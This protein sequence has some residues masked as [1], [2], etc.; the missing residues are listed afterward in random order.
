MTLPGKKAAVEFCWNAYSLCD[1][2]EG[3]LKN[4]NKRVHSGE[5]NW[6]SEAKSA[7]TMLRRTDARSWIL[8]PS[9]EAFLEEVATW[10]SQI[11]ARCSPDAVKRLWHAIS[12]ST[13]M[14]GSKGVSLNK[15]WMDHA[16]QH[17][18]QLVSASWHI[19]A[20]ANASELTKASKSHLRALRGGDP[21][22]LPRFNNSNLRCQRLQA[23]DEK[24]QE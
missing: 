14:F 1:R 11:F 21:L 3:H 7:L 10:D 15:V 20:G 12:D 13:L 16:Q 24:C 5:F 17:E 6:M 9:V 4:S 2:A 19:K 18:N 23:F 8:S 22:E